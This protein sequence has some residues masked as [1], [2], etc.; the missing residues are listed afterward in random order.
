M[1]IIPVD[2]SRMIIVVAVMGGFVL[3]NLVLVIECREVGGYSAQCGE[4]VSLFNFR[5]LKVDE[6]VLLR[7]KVMDP[8]FH[9]AQIQSIEKGTGI[10]NS[11]NHFIFYQN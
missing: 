3:V 7:Y 11:F 6:F 10:S 2:A 1:N 9:F 4:K 8:E 5:H